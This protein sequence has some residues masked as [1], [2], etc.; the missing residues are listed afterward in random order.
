[1]YPFTPTPH[2]LT[3]PT[4]PTRWTHTRKERVDDWFSERVWRREPLGAGDAA[5]LGGVWLVFHDGTALC[6]RIVASLRGRGLPVATVHPSDT[7][8]VDGDRFQICPRSREDYL[9]LIAE[10]TILIGA[11]TRLIHAWCANL[12]DEDAPI[13]LGVK[14]L[15][16]LAAA[17]ETAPRTERRLWVTAASMHSVLGTEE[18]V[19][20][21]AT[22]LGPARVLPSETPGLTCT[23]IDLDASSSPERSADDIVDEC[24]AVPPSI[25]RTVAYRAG[26][27][28]VLDDV[29][30]QLPR[31]TG[32]WVRPG[33]SYAITGGT[34]ALGQALAA[35]IAA[36]GGDVFLLARTPANPIPHSEDDLVS[37]AIRTISVDVTVPGSLGAA[38]RSV[39]AETTLRGVFHLAG[40]PGAGLA[41]FKDLDDVDRVLRPKIVGADELD[42]ALAGLDVD[43]VLCYGSNAANVGSVGQIDYAAANSYLDAYAWSRSDVRRTITIDWG[44]WREAG[45]AIDALSS[46]RTG[47]ARRRE[48]R[49]QG[50]SNAEGLAAL[51]AILE[52]SR[53]PQIIVSPMDTAALLEGSTL[54]DELALISPNSA[55]P[56]EAHDR[57]ASLDRYVP[58]TTPLAKSACRAWTQVLGI[59]PIG[60]NDSFLDL[61]G[62]SLLAI[63]L[64]ANINDDLNSH[65]SVADLY[66]GLT[67][68]H[69]VSLIEAPGEAEK[70]DVEAV[71]LRTEEAS[72]RRRAQ[73][74][75]K[76]ARSR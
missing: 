27:R 69:L 44:T 1:T 9:R 56:V 71:K 35:H 73:E 46:G 59:H 11:P 16:L 12:S 37:G 2:R 45:M 62:D 28:W 14:S 50:M 57:P 13:E 4:T 47:D 3:T 49:R 5:T 17:L 64:I 15:V 38:L 43:F 60:I 31:G 22:L 75:R 26:R 53:T 66:A 65:L 54:D 70:I 76:A 30:V 48:I 39:S 72:R 18:V 67:V 68:A 61:G 40:E 41:K 20:I 32:A 6:D 19:P 51:D 42:A 36:R 21:R 24:A 8:T 58:P 33:A 25:H 52:H 34:G 7:Y 10:T 23:A 29:P 55:S 74:R 63:Q